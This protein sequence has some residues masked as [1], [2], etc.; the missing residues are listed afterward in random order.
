MLPPNSDIAE[1][2]M[3]VTAALQAAVPVLLH[4]DTV[5]DVLGRCIYTACA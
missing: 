5:I 3:A 2:Q 4:I 1:H